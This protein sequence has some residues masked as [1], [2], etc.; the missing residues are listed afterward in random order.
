MAKKSRFEVARSQLERMGFKIPASNGAEKGNIF[1]RLSIDSNLAYGDK[2]SVRL[3]IAQDSSCGSI[4]LDQEQG[5]ALA[6]QLAK[7]FLTDQEI[8]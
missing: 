2:T 6:R 4:Y 8:E 1:A 5:A 3:W 7:L